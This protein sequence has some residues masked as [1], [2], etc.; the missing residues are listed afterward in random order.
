MSFSVS[1]RL[2]R[3]RIA[4]ADLGI[5]RVGSQG[6]NSSKGVL[7]KASPWKFSHRRAKNLGGGVNPLTP[8]DPT[9]DK[10][11]ILTE[12]LDFESRSLN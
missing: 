2:K 3:L 4:R 5:L 12:S 7:D 8:L 11:I 1:P 9:L 10:C 6:R